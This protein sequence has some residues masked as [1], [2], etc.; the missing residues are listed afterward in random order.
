MRQSLARHFDVIDTSKPKCGA[1]AAACQCAVLRRQAMPLVPT[2]DQHDA[3][4]LDTASRRC[5][6]CRSPLGHLV[7]HGPLPITVC[8]CSRSRQHLQRS[9][10]LT[11]GTSAGLSSTECGAFTR[12]PSPV[13]WVT[14]FCQANS[15]HASGVQQQQLQVPNDTFCQHVPTRLATRQ[16]TQ[17]GAAAPPV[18]TCNL[19][20]PRQCTLHHCQPP[21]SCPH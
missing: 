6:H 20:L 2:G 8:R 7:P 12:P 13:V 15:E 16:P 21:L 18:K 9:A 3:P 1:A 19:C 14:A 4:G 10:N 11:G 5:H 17:H